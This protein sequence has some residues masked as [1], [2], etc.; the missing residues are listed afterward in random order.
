MYYFW[1][2]IL[3]NPK[4][5]SVYKVGG[6]QVQESANWNGDFKKKQR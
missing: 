6:N 4:S 5:A 1:P 3:I 2:R